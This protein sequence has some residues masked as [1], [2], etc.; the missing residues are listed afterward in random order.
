MPVDPATAELADASAE[1]VAQKWHDDP[2]LPRPWL[3]AAEVATL[4]RLDVRGLEAMRREG[5]GPAG[6]ALRDVIH[7]AE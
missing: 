4:L 3:K 5:R 2:P 7:R 1:R 6:Q